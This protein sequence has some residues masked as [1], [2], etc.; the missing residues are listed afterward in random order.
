LLIA[1]GV[2]LELPAE[3]ER[4]TPFHTR[5]IWLT[6][7]SYLLY[8]FYFIAK[9]STWKKKRGAILVIVLGCEERR[10]I[11]VSF[12]RRKIEKRSNETRTCIAF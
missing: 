11:R 3:S 9:D 1:N 6:T 2:E 4:K 5:L 7:K 10:V 8:L 12:C